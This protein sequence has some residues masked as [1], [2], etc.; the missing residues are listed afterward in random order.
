MLKIV[1]HAKYLASNICDIVNSLS[2]PYKTGIIIELTYL[3]FVPE[4]IKIRYGSNNIRERC[5]QAIR[6]ED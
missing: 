2:T 5:L 3:K 1:F 4:P 6:K